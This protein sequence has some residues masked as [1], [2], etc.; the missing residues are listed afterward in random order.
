MFLSLWKYRV[1]APVI[2]KLSTRQK[3]EQVNKAELGIWIWEPLAEVSV[4]RFISVGLSVKRHECFGGCPT[5][6]FTISEPQDQEIGELY[7]VVQE[8]LTTDFEAHFF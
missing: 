7:V 5:G 1:C 4:P 2:L 6:L 3:K 8:R